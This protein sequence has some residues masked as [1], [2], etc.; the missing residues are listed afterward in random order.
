MHLEFLS[1]FW[2]I[3]LLPVIP[4]W[5]F[6]LRTREK[7][8]DLLRFAGMI[9][10]ILALAEPR[11]CLERPGGTL[12]VLADRSLSLSPEAG[13]HQKELIGILEKTRSPQ[14]RLVLFSF[15]G[16][17]ALEKSAEDSAFE[18]FRAWHSGTS[19]NLA[20]ALEE[21]LA[22]TG[23]GAEAPGWRAAGGGRI[24]ILSDGLWNGVPP[25]D[26]AALAAGRG[27]PVDYRLMDSA[28]SGNDMAVLSLDAPLESAPGEAFQFSASV[29]LPADGILEYQL[30][31]DTETVVASGKISLKAGTHRLSF[32]D[33]IERAGNAVYRLQ[34]GPAAGDPHPE[35]NVARAVTRVDGPK[36]VLIVGAGQSRFPELAREGG[37]SVLAI[38]P[39]KMEWTSAVLSRFSAVVLENV[40]ADKIG[41][42]G[43]TALKHFV[44][45]AGGAL[46]MTGG[47][48]SFGTGGY[49]ASPLESVLPVSMELRKEHRRLKTSVIVAL[50][51]SGSMSAG[52]PDGRT[53]MDLANHGTA[54]LLELLSDGDRIGVLAVDSKA[55]V[56]LPLVAVREDEKPS[57]AGRIRQIQ[58]MGGGIYVFEALS[59]AAAMLLTEE[60]GT[61]HIILFADASDSEEPG[62]YRKLIGHLRSNGITLSVI[63]LGTPL[64]PDAPLL[65]EIAEL[66]GGNLHFAETPMELPRLFSQE[67][68]SIFRNAFQTDRTPVLKSEDLLLL[69]PPPPGDPPDI[70]GFN[71]TYL[72]PG[73]S[74]GL[75]TGD[76]FRAPVMA[77]WQRGCGRVAVFTNEVDGEFSGPFAAWKGS[78]EIY[79]SVL[80]WLAGKAEDLPGDAFFVRSESLN[81]S[82]LITLELDPDRKRDPFI[83]LPEL[84]TIHEDAETT[85]SRSF[86]FEWSTKDTLRCQIPLPESGILSCFVE[87]RFREEKSAPD[88]SSSFSSSLSSPLSGSHAV[89]AGVFTRIYPEEFRPETDPA[90]GRKTLERIAETTGGKERLDMEGIFRDIRPQQRSLPL[91]HLAAFLAA[92]FL[93]LEIAWLRLGLGRFPILRQIKE[94][95]ATNA[96][97]GERKERK[98]TDGTEK[99]RRNFWPLR[100]PRLRKRQGKPLSDPEEEKGAESG[101]GG[102]ESAHPP[103]LTPGSGI[104]GGSG[105]GKSSGSPGENRLS[106]E[107]RSLSSALARA[108]EKG[109]KRF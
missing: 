107:K 4:G 18:N 100:L 108:K 34:I 109:R 7:I 26:A 83:S 89:P 47:R 33:R 106:Q 9:L 25:F 104:P 23:G 22:F 99:G 38:P 92:L 5:Y 103:A 97:A 59:R 81:G 64:D 48:T 94:A 55:H 98:K 71:L 19:S 11:L 79:L 42:R 96:D 85:E 90:R 68:I 37:L 49:F 43:Q 57:L 14:D 41:F 76:S 69:L 70:G 21:A 51:R 12:L 16:E 35:N 10:V 44:E 30:T 80:R 17:S 27:I 102:K 95:I 40:P 13:E 78:S 93:L 86:P 82:A 65:S 28:S 36:P 87:T 84:R 24:L 72:K 77:F 53:K 15:S 20:D 101:N 6:F 73:A 56:V 31:R 8:P 75:I 46:M 67:A 39:E 54:S 45:D 74:A 52:T 50:D 3:L 105:D 63:G 58:A 2:L 61:R 66:G 62:E 32:Q 29:I 91:H 60:S 1:S 88:A